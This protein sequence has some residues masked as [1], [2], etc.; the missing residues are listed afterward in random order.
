[1]MA[2]ITK[3]ITDTQAECQDEAGI[4]FTASL[5]ERYL[6]EGLAKFV[7]ETRCL[8]G[9]VTMPLTMLSGGRFHLAA[10]VPDAI[11][12]LRV[13]VGGRKLKYLSGDQMAT[14]P[15]YPEQ[16][17]APCYYSRETDGFDYLSLHPYPDPTEAPPTIRIDY[18]RAGY[19]LLDGTPA[20][21]PEFHQ[22]LAYYAIA[23]LMASD[24]PI[25]QQAK[26]PQYVELYRAE[27]A[28]CSTLVKAGFQRK[29]AGSKRHQRTDWF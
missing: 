12:V 9:S 6:L 18:V 4:Y 27:V 25:A 15:G 14:Q 23:R 8:R 10:A 17:G 29:P 24:I 19:L 13:T 16:L 22:A 7:E 2:T 28:R 20:I 11:E 5:C 26:A 3:L 21:P 1:M